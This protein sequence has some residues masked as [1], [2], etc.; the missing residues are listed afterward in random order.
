MTERVRLPF[1]LFPCGEFNALVRAVVDA[2]AFVLDD[3]IAEQGEQVVFFG[4][5]PGIVPGEVGVDQVFVMGKFDLQP[6]P[7]VLVIAKLDEQG[8]LVL[9]DHGGRRVR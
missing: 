5:I 7:V 4:E 6:F 3:A 8:D 9:L 2:D 1:E